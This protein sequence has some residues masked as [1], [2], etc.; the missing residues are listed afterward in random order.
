M[1]TVEQANKIEWDAWIH[2]KRSKIIPFQSERI[3]HQILIIASII[4]KIL[5]LYNAVKRI[6][7]K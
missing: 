1:Y 6:Y 7:R 5:K 3:D 2:N 4:S